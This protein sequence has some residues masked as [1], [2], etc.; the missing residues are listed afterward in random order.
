[1][2]KIKKHL[3]N[4]IALI[5]TLFFLALVIYKVDISEMLNTF[6]LFNLKDLIFL[7]PLYIIIMMLRAKR[8]AILLPE[9]KCYFYN[10]YE[11]YML[12]NL[13]NIFLPARAGD[14]FRGYYFGQKYNLSKMNTIGTVAAERILDGLTVIFILFLGIILYNKSEMAIH[15]A[16]ISGIIFI[17]S[18]MLMFWIYKYD[19]IDQ[20]CD[21]I[22]KKTSFLPEKYRKSLYFFIDKTS[23]YIK[24]FIKGFE[25][26]ANPNKLFQAILYSIYSWAGDCIFIYLLIIA[27]GIKVN[28]IASF[29]VISFIA[30]S[31]ILPSTSIYIGLYQYAFIL[32]L[33]LFGI[34]KSPALSISIMQQGLLLII[35][36]II[37]IIF[38]FRN[39][40]SIKEIKEDTC[41]EIK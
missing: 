19:K 10:L 14:I 39:H 17:F 4:I 7:T 16:I 23:P 11:I 5:I 28:F 8:W 30:L 25:S 31:T 12:S 24:S 2:K 32:A 15:L 27:F 22:K 34:D 13:L 18:F 36:L 20:L 6:K 3:K 33:G 40:I 35:Y 9:N 41:I 1:M 38:V 26:F 29:F 21:Y 37:S